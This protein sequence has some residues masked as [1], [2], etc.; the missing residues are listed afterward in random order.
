M[1]RGVEF[2]EVET[3]GAQPSPIERGMH[4]MASTNVGKRDR[5]RENKEKEINK[6]GERISEHVGRVALALVASSGIFVRLF[7]CS[8]LLFFPSSLPP[9]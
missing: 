1:V 3:Q 4:A 9:P 6:Q 8:L 5:K 7:V 2:T